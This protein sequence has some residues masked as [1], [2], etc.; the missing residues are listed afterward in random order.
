MSGEGAPAACRVGAIVVN[1][2]AGPAL[3]ACVESL[4][5]AGVGE[6][7]V[8]DNASTDG[9]LAALAAAD[10]DVVL[11]PTG[12]NLGY[13]TAVNR[14]AERAAAEYLLV[15]N[16]DVVV[17]EALPQALLAV[18]DA[19]GD[20]A[21]CGPRIDSADGTRYPSARA[22]PTLGVAIGHAFVGLFRPNNRWSRRYRLEDDAQ[23]EHDVDWVSGACLLVRRTAFEAVG[24]FDERYFMYV[25]D[26]DLC[27]RL[28]RAGW[29]VRYVPKAS[30][31]HLQGVSSARRPYRMLV[32]HHASTWRFARRSAEGPERLLLPVVGAGLLARLAV[33]LGQQLA[34][35]RHAPR[36]RS[37]AAVD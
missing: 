5:R 4:R 34:V 30:A 6:V 14:G 11:L 22:F 18:L 25:E 26:L 21:L 28:R 37:H 31:V 32:A 9:S 8:V 10:G 27:W 19:H 17:D 15:C 35:T 3:L 29:R 7:V 16:P 2:D 13:G 20:V 23:D 36:N 24:G 12:R 33:A 1:H